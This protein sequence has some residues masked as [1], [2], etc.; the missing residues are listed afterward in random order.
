ADG[1]GGGGGGGGG[2]RAGGNRVGRGG[3]GGLPRFGPAK[4]GAPPRD[5]GRGIDEGPR[6]GREPLQA[7][8]QQRIVSAGEHDGVGAPPA[9]IDE[10]GRDLLRDQI[11]GDG[12]ATE[13]GL[14]EA[15]K[16]RRADQRDVA[17]VGEV[18]DQRTGIFAADRPFGAEHRH[19]LGARA[20]AGRLDRR[21]A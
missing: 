4:R 6:P 20:R 3:G 18:T 2:G 19:A 1:A 14:R 11:I 8:E 7:L 15:R 13:L 5:R 9:G 10:T 17:A 16:P 21:H 12:R